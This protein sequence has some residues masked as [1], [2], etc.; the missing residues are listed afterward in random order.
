MILIQQMISLLS[1]YL[2]IYFNYNIN[3]YINKYLNN[4]DKI[5]RF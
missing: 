5:G 2:I 1:N 4:I 3:K